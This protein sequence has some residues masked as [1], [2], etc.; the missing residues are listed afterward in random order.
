MARVLQSEVTPMTC[1]HY[2]LLAL[3]LGLTALMGADV[4]AATPGDADAVFSVDG[5]AVTDVGAPDPVADSIALQPDGRVVMAVHSTALQ[6]A[7]P[8][9]SLY[10]VRLNSDGSLDTSFGE[11]GK[12]LLPDGG[13]YFPVHMDVAVT[14]TGRIL[15]SAFRENGRSGF[16]LIG[17]RPDGE[18]DTSFGG[19]D[20]IVSQALEKGSVLTE[21][22]ALAPDGKIVV[23]GAYGGKTEAGYAVGRLLEDGTPDPDFSDDGF[24]VALSG[25]FDQAHLGGVAVR[26][27]GRVVIAGSANRKGSHDQSVAAVQFNGD[28]T[29]DAG[30]SG[31]G[32]ASLDAPGGG[33]DTDLALDN[34]GRLLV[35]RTDVAAGCPKPSV[36]VRFAPDGAADASFGSGGVVRLSRRQAGSP[37]PLQFPEIA[38]DAS[39]R[40]ILLSSQRALTIVR[41]TEAG[42]PDASFSGNGFATLY[43]PSARFG[44]DT[45]VTGDVLFSGDFLLASST[46]ST[47]SGSE[48]AVARFGLVD[49]PA[50]SDGDGI[51]DAK[52]PCFEIFGPC[53]EFRSK[54]RARHDRKKSLLRGRVGGD[55]ACSVD[56]KVELL[57]KRSRGFTRVSKTRASASSTFAFRLSHAPEGRYKVH[58]D[59]L[60]L[61]FANCASASSKPVDVGR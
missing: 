9:T 46:A 26:E 8:V 1:L 7:T 30:F 39:S 21:N 11:E 24:S 60:K 48:P 36:V 37:C 12:V 13:T 27:D 4:A 50:D 54:V 59:E 5:I 2:R 58:V 10:I 43:S 61:T 44:T 56:R 23:A 14:P 32:V 17:L 16:G 34:Q 15:T 53:L 45:P 33:G 3:V 49:G 47:V 55:L 42:Q 41:L 52:E 28:G 25:D 6:A 38:A 20:G 40:P 51:G 18:L 29:L 22:I 35:A 57:R 19:G 31:D